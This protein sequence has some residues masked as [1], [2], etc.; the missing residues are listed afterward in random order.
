LKVIELGLLSSE[1]GGVLG[2]LG[3]IELGFSLAEHDAVLVEAVATT[4]K[5]LDFV[6]SEG[7]RPVG[8]VG[9]D[10]DF[11]GVLTGHETLIESEIALVVGGVRIA[12]GAH[13]DQSDAS[14][15]FLM[16]RDVSLDLE[17]GTNVTN[18]RIDPRGRNPSTLGRGV[19]LVARA[20]V[21]I[22]A[23]IDRIVVMGCQVFDEDVD[24][25]TST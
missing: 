18:R 3:Q 12:R 23:K 9:R 22:G 8:L 4:L 17:G 14:S 10:A 20:G 7:I 2:D 16:N 11:Y 15:G 5:D 19:A 13:D 21:K 24:A 25:Y 6:D 1:Q